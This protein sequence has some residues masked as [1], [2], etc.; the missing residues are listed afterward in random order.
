MDPVTLGDGRSLQL[1]VKS[2]N[3]KGVAIVAAAEIN[4]R[5][6]AEALRGQTVAIARSSLPDR[7]RM[8]CIMLIYWGC[9]CLPV[10]A[11]LLADCWAA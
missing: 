7:L 2:V 6:A 8:S 3:A 5:D 4:T 11:S 1:K 10:T 9:G